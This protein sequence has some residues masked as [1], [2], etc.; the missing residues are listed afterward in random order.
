MRPIS[1]GVHWGMKNELQSNGLPTGLRVCTNIID[2]AKE[3]YV[4]L[5]SLDPA[6]N[7]KAWMENSIGKL[8]LVTDEFGNNRLSW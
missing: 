8:I 6:K 7:L 3:L 4:T 2:P 5:V 1:L